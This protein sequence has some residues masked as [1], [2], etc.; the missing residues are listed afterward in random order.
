M[1]FEII[2]VGAD[3]R[4]AYQVTKTTAQLV[5]DTGEKIPVSGH[6]VRIFER[7][8]DGSWKTKVHM[9]NRPNAP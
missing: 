7:Q 4:Y 5:R 1:K 9:F 2:D 3:G 6:T 8:R